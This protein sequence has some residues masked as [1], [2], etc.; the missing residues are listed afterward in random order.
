LHTHPYDEVFVVQEGD[1]TFTV[2]DVIVEAKGGQIVVAP[3]GTPHKVATPATDGPGISTSIPAG[4]SA[5]SG[6]RAKKKPGLQKWRNDPVKLGLQLNSFDWTGSP[7]RIGR[8]LVDIARTA[9]EA[10]FDRIA[11]ADHVWQHP[12]VGVRRQTHQSA[13]RRWLSW[14]PIRSGPCHWSLNK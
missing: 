1:L 8:T 9:E 11:V 2:G 13:T 14:P 12:I 10:G 7:E 3:A 4:A 6:S 5:P